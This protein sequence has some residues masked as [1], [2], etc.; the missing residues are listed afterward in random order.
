MFDSLT[1]IN[2]VP[3]DKFSVRIDHALRITSLFEAHVYEQFFVE[4]T[5]VNMN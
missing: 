1:L 5:A 4:M 3:A 2:F